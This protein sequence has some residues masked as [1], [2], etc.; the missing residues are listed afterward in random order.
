M[1]YPLSTR[2]TGFIL[3]LILTLM[4][5]F[6]IIQPAVWHLD[7]HTAVITIFTLA[8]VQ[9][10]VQLICFISVW[11][12]EGTHWN[13]WIFASTVSIIFIVVFFSVWIID[14]LNYNMR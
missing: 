4:T 6:I 14:H 8:L 5:Y 13:F 7:I 3:S 1:H 10:L 2:I 9:S 12:E 11:K